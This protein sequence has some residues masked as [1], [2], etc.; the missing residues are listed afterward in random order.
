[1]DFYAFLK[2]FLANWFFERQRNKIRCDGRVLGG[3]RR[4]VG[5]W[6][7][8]KEAWVAILKQK[9]SFEKFLSTKRREEIEKL[10][11]NGEERILKMR[12]RDEI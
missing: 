8:K 7:S 5:S 9:E 4:F 2:Y 11:E 3:M 10:R 1:M 12:K 6:R